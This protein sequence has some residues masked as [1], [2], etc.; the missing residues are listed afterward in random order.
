VI[1][2]GGTGE[3]SSPTLGGPLPLDFSVLL[4][5]FLFLNISCRRPLRKYFESDCK[6]VDYCGYSSLTLV[7]Y[8]VNHIY[9]ALGADGAAILMQFVAAGGGWVRRFYIQGEGGCVYRSL[10]SLF[11]FHF[12]ELS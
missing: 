10:S 5:A 2:P 7:N 3:L 6:T 11:N 9:N 8:A 4:L 12:A 1:F